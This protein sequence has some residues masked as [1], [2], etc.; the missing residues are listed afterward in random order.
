MTRTLTVRDYVGDLAQSCEYIQQFVAGASP[1]SFQDNV[2]MQFSVIRALEL[3]GEA[4]GQLLRLHPAA[5]ARLSEI[6][7]RQMY[8]TRNRLIHG[9]TSVAADLVWR[10]VE[11]EIPELRRKL[12]ALL[13]NWP[14]D[15]T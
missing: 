8:A 4:A 12:K 5:A 3:L 2:M 14:V 11:D 1:R 6:P 13:A 15:L 9:Y 7:L 10:I